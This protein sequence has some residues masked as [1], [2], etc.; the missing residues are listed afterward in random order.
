M[1]PDFDQITDSS[2]KISKRFRIL[3]YKS[4]GKD[5]GLLIGI[6]PDEVL[7]LEKGN[8]PRKVDIILAVHKGKFPEG[9]DGNKYD[10]LIHPEVMEGGILEG[11]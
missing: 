2:S 8:E 6:R 3:P 5:K 10:L 4:V 7:L 11:E 1:V 9:R